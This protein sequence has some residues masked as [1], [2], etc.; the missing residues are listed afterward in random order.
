MTKEGLS[1]TRRTGESCVCFVGDKEIEVI[2]E[3]TT[4]NKVRL[5]FVADETVKIWRSELLKDGDQ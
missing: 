1:L 5:R 4:I 2:I 3:Q